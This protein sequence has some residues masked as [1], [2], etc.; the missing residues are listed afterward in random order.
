MPAID[1]PPINFPQK[2]VICH[3]ASVLA[4]NLC[5][6]SFKLPPFNSWEI[7]SIGSDASTS[8]PAF[9]FGITF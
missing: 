2:M 6:S 5:D 3:T 4:D 7:N 1:G 8:Q 9:I